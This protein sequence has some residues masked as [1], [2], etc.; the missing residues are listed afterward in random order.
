MKITG[1]IKTGTMID[2]FVENNIQIL[3]ATDTEDITRMLMDV[4]PLEVPHRFHDVL[5]R[6]KE[7]R[8]MGLIAEIKKSSPSAGALRLD[9]DV[10]QQA[11]LYSSGNAT[12]LSVVTQPL[13]FSGSLEDLEIV[14][15][16]VSQPVLRKDF[17]IYPAQIYEAR[18]V[19]AAAVLLIAMILE[20]AA[21]K[22][23]VSITND[24]GMDA[25]VEVHTPSEVDSAVGSRARLIGINA[26]SLATMEVHL[27]T[28]VNILPML[29]SHVIRIAESGIETYGDVQRV[30]QAGADAVLV[31]TTLMRP[32]NTIET[33]RELIYG[34]EF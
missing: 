19:G 23:L 21:L 22:E 29:P 11:S 28:V 15:K 33:M 18:R 31:G 16:T 27:S 14:T 26:R 34:P 13:K 24:L 17:I 1:V 12:A 8:T 30:Q 9:V 10:A 4:L 6:Q 32:G 20:P 7:Q 2:E 25:V 3:T 5:A